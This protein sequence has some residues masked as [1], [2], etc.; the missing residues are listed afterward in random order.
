LT[1]DINARALQAFV[2]ADHSIT[3]I[4]RH[5]EIRF[6]MQRSAKLV[7]TL[8]IAALFTAACGGS[9]TNTNTNTAAQPTPA[10]KAAN[11]T[12]SPAATDASNS[13]TATFKAFY[14]ASKSGDEEAFKKTVSK[15]TLAMLEEGAKEKKKTLSQ[16]LKESDVPP[17]MPETRNEKIDGD[18]ATIEVKDEK[19]GA[20]ETIKFVKEDG[21][22]KIVLDK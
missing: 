14:E 3:L 12:P 9:S 8:S 4:Q 11:T 16:A 17:T 15:D 19:T 21:R 7:L 5:K 18:K 1:V 10:A 6:Q 22:W 13:P 2:S 20:W